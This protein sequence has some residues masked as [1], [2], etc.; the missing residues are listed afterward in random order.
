M[1]DKLGQ[2][3]INVA[4]LSVALAKLC[5]AQVTLTHSV[6]N[7]VIAQEKTNVLIVNL[8][9]DTTAGCGKCIAREGFTEST[10]GDTKSGRST[11]DQEYFTPHAVLG[12]G[13]RLIGT[14]ELLEQILMDNAVDMQTVLLAQ[15]V[16]RAFFGTIANSKHVQSKL[17]F[18]SPSGTNWTVGA[19]ILN[20][21]LISSQVLRYLPLWLGK[22]ESE[23]YKNPE[24]EHRGHKAGDHHI[25][26][27]EVKI[28]SIVTTSIRSP[29]VTKGPAHYLEISLQTPSYSKAVTVVSPG[30]WQ[31]MHFTQPTCPLLLIAECSYEHYMSRDNPRD[32][33]LQG[34]RIIKEVANVGH[35]LRSVKRLEYSDRG[36]VSRLRYH[37]HAEFYAALT[38]DHVDKGAE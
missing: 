31:R 11:N 36:D 28:Q 23:R 7:L 14:F 30:S 18:T 16:N 33:D 10:N 26:F 29:T 24:F 19:P 5:E 35:L 15:R 8:I 34:W 12:P 37:R 21:L 22:E 2:G 13:T 9:K 32:R 1:S 27:E 38:S 4:G 6:N 17:F 25:S 20:P 3:D